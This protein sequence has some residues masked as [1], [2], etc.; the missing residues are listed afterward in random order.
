[1]T[2][3]DLISRQYVIEMLEATA[4]ATWEIWERDNSDYWL[5][6]IKGIESAIYIVRNLP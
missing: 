5:N 1:M 6:R 3:Q 2:D 4:A